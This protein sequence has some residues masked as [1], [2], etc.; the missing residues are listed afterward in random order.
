MK[1]LGWIALALAALVAGAAL[2]FVAARSGPPDAD[3]PASLPP[4]RGARWAPET[5]DL[6]A[7]LPVQEGGRVKPFSTYASFT[8]LAL[9]GKRSATAPE[10]AKLSATEWAMDCLFFPEEAAKTECFLVQDAQVLDAAGLAHEGKNRRDRYSYESLAPGRMRFFEIASRVQDIEPSKRDAVQ[11]QILHLAQNLMRFEQLAGSLRFAQGTPTGAASRAV[12]MTMGAD[13]APAAWELV[14]RAPDLRMFVAT[15]GPHGPAGGDPALSAWF[16]GA[17]RGSGGP[18]LVPPPDGAEALAEWSSPGEVV[19][20]A[21]TERPAAESEVA[22]LRS[23]CAMAAARGDRDAF[24]GAARAFRDTVVRAAESR[25]EYAKIPLEVSYYRAGWLHW[26]QAGFVLAFLLA[27]FSWIRGSRALSR[28]ATW[29]AVVGIVALAAAVTLR[30]VIRG[31]PPVTTLYES[32]L[33]VTAVAAIA[34]LVAERFHRNGIGLAL[35]TASGAAGLFVAN[36]YETH[37]AVDTMPSLVAV[38]D[39]NFWL[40]SHVTTITI[41]YGA[42]LL[43]GLVSHVWILGKAFGLRRRDPGFY[44]SL[45]SM[46]YAMQAFGLL[47][48]V[49]GTVLGGIWANESWG[50]FW[51]W[52][53][54]ENGALAIVLWQTILL[55]ARLGGYVRDFGLAMMSVFGAVVVASS[56]WGVNLLGVGLHSYGFTSGILSLLLAYYAFEGLV[57][58]VGAAHA[59]R[60][61]RRPAVRT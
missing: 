45:T 22:A 40:A 27:A 44:R 51:G 20:S 39:T 42:G 26:A 8:L 35:A 53:P 59:I 24:A 38:L 3:R 2:A 28:A 43:A 9:N 41:G 10:G 15:G 16:D 17:T 54:K 5:V 11:S 37:E 30:C 52:D 49:V 60:E 18:A 47:F 6:F 29:S 46:T 55:H 21:F 36:R 34:A 23:I 32:I 4:G 12:A 7:R 25:G 57:M 1:R 48:A 31:R 19:S 56:W 61:R 14:D 58:A 33:F 13:V 50:R